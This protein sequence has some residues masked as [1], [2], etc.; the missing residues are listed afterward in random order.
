QGPVEI[1]T[2]RLWRLAM[3][4][5]VP[6]RLMGMPTGPRPASS[7]AITA[8]GVALRSITETLLSGTSFFGSAASS[9]MLEDMSANDSSGAIATFCGGPP[10]PEGALSSPT[11]LGGGTPGSS[12][13]TV[14]SAG[15]GG[16]VFT[17]LTSTALASLAETASCAAASDGNN[18][19][20][21]RAAA[22]PL[23]REM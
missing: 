6:A 1:G 5:G 7:V 3:G 21:R 17:P 11:A 2:V 22:S 12:M 8:G 13:V 15:F 20:I 18:G 23:A 10:T 14:S 4:A 9:F 19:P 16:T